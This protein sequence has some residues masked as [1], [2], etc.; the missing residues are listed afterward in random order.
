MKVAKNVIFC[1]VAI[2]VLLLQ[3]MTPGSVRADGKTPPPA[4]ETPVET[5]QPATDVLPADP[6]A[7]TSPTKPGPIG[8]P[9]P[10]NSNT[11]PDVTETSTSLPNKQP[12]LLEAALTLSNDT[13]VIV[14]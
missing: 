2:A 6:D 10:D 1:F 5:K 8:T 4:T 13:S 12:T 7:D 11:T 14:V 3:L 9:T